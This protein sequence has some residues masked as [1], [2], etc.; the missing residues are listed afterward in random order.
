MKRKYFSA[1]LMGAL[2][3]AS[4]STF[5]SCKDYDDDIKDLQTQIDA[6]KSA[7][8][9]ISK[10]IKDG[11]VITSVDKATSGVTVKLS[12]GDTFTIN[13]G[14]D[15]V[16]GTN[17]KDGVDGTPGTVWTIGKDGYWYCDGVK[18]NYKAVGEK[19][20]KGDKGDQGEPGQDGTSTGTKGDKGDAGENGK[21]YVPNPDNNYCFDIYQDGKF[22]EHTN[23]SYIS[24]TT[25]KGGITALLDKETLTLYGV[26]GGTGQNGE[27]RISLNGRLSSLVFMPYIYMDG[28]EAIE[29]NW[30]DGKTLAPVAFENTKNHQDLEVKY[31][32][33]QKNLNDNEV[34]WDYIA[35][36]GKA[37][38]Y[39]PAWEVDYHANPINSNV[40][41]ADVD[42]FNIL[43]PEAYYHTRAAGSSLG[44][45]SPE[46][47][48][49][50]D[51][52]K[53]AKKLFNMADDGVLTVGLQIA[54][55]NL[56]NQNPTVKTLPD[57]NDK[58]DEN[59][60]YNSPNTVALKVKN[61]LG[62]DII[63]DYALLQPTKS[64]IEGMYWRSAPDYVG[65]PLGANGD[66]DENGKSGQTGDELC[67][68]SNKVLHVWDSPEEALKDKRGAALELFWDDTNGINIEDYVGIHLTKNNL[69][70][71]TKLLSLTPKQALQYGLTFHYD[72]VLYLVGSNLTS[73]SKYLV[74]TNGNTDDTDGNFR[75]WNVKHDETW[76]GQTSTTAVGREPLIQVRVT[77]V[78]G[79]VV[80]DGYI[81]LHIT[82]KAKDNL[83]VETWKEQ[84]AE[85]D[86]CDVTTVF[87][88]TW[89]QFND[90][91]L[92]EGLSNMTKEDF[93]YQYEA[94][95]VDNTNYGTATD[96]VYLMKIFSDPIAAK[97][98]TKAED[99]N[100]SLGHVLYKPNDN[101]TTN[102]TWRWEIDEDQM[103]DLLHHEASKT[104]T[105][106][107]RFKAKGDKQN[108][109]YPYIYVKMTTTIT[110]K[111][112]S[113]KFGTKDA[114][115]W[116][117]FNGSEDGWD[118]IVFNAHRPTDGGSIATIN[119]T[120]T[121]TLEGN[122]ENTFAKNK[123]HKYYF[124]PK[125]VKITTQ[126][127]EYTITPVGNA[128]L[129]YYVIN[130]SNRPAT[131]TAI[132]TAINQAKGDKLICKYSYENGDPN[133]CGDSQE[134]P[135]RVDEQHKVPAYDEHAWSVFDE[136]NT[137][138]KTCAIDY[139][140]GAFQ[141]EYLFAKKGNV[142]T[143]IAKLN[144]VTGEINLIHTKACEYVLN[145]IGYAEKHANLNV[146]MRSWVGVVAA[147]GC[148]V[149][150]TVKDGEFMV[151]WERPITLL[152]DEVEP[153]VDAKDNHNYIYAADFLKLFDWRGQ[154]AG[155]GW[156][157]HTW[158]W[159]YYNVQ[160]ITIDVTPANVETTLGE[161][162][163]RKLSEV[164][165]NE[166]AL[167]TKDALTSM[168]SNKGLGEFTLDLRSY[169]GAG[170]PNDN[171]VSYMTG[172]SKADFGYIMYTN[173]GDNV[174][175]FDLKVPVTLTYEWGEFKTVVTIKVNN[176][177]GN[178]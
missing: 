39:G 56:L 137:L 95:L 139:N 80:L 21:Y 100:E 165:P 176:T 107:I 75:V 29:Y 63:S 18:Q 51:P 64:F 55:P 62:N 104:I 40:K 153:V 87:K 121:S 166:L 169:N 24:N 92:T 125:E 46:Y 99:N 38:V 163:W 25:V 105:R 158:Y 13:N 32:S 110:R 9:Q 8:E 115:Y 52:A 175:T 35:K 22:V 118:A 149:A 140:K 177:L 53:G 160:K 136:S 109:K 156:N 145:A 146:Q 119:R 78:D 11:C 41:Y 30:L 150:E 14:K 161:K 126:D 124:E 97:G 81:L 157:D 85:F 73:D 72:P 173:N 27:V 77:N 57:W 94:D 19:G 133:K 67:T 83:V 12:N 116:Y 34:K 54:H 143:P 61:D 148:D 69:D 28:I 151:S 142:V 128:S 171:L 48:F 42:N 15:G 154:T 135:A 96:P 131:E 36:G 162:G 49:P 123:A 159:A 141:N 167:Y 102:H 120:I 3:I 103:E 2:A 20:D 23:I 164:S 59:G 50:G 65:A 79:D 7:I 101:G 98:N 6:N 88:T 130:R 178:H 132:N 117:A 37:F 26:T 60:D 111:I 16:D 138:A 89:A 76:Q 17:G 113:E 144:P 33:G 174:S 74:K 82:D 155:Y 45:T 170:T 134:S 90:W 86:Q 58:A 168:P 114:S 93:D 106:Y 129:P 71:T 47:A 152:T 91:F 70:G 5:T 84:T 4:T 68:P 172:T 10:L 112:N 66:V 122:T 1:L 127:G 31:P 44:V 43:E 147:N 108:A